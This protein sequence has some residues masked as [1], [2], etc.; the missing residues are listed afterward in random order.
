MSSH[1]CAGK[2]V[3]VGLNPCD[4]FTQDYSIGEHVGLKTV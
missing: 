3:G 1:L 2:E 4:D